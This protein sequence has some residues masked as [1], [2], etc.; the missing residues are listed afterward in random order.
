MKFLI[1]LLIIVAIIALLG[2][3]GYKT[4]GWLAERNKPRFKTARVETG[5]L[6]ISVN[7]SGEVNPVLKVKVGSFVSGPILKLHVDYNTEVKEGDP[8]ADID[9]RIYDAAVARDEA[10]LLT[11]KAD[12]LR[13]QAELQ[14]AI[15]DEKR[16]IALKSENPEFISQA[17]LDQY[18]FSR[19]ALEAQLQV[20]EAGVSQADAN[21]E[22][23]KANV[24]YTK[25]TSPVDGVVIDRKIDPG[26]TLAAQ[27]QT[28][29]LFVIAP[30]MREK[31]HIQASVDEA[32]IGLIKQAEATKQPVFFSV[33]AYPDVVFKDAII[34]QIRIAPT[35]AQNVVTYPVIVATPNPDLKLLPGMTA[36]LTFQVSELKNILKV[37]N[38]AL[39]YNPEKQHVRYI[40]HKYLELAIAQD[41]KDDE[42]KSSLEPPVDDSIAAAKAAMKRV[43]WVQ[44]TAVEAAELAKAKLEEEAKKSGK[45]APAAPAAAGPA[46]DPVTGLPA[47]SGKLKAVEIYIGDSD[48]RFTQV[49]SGNLKDGDLIVTGLKPPEAP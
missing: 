17:E 39:R 27:F 15:N 43:V 22:N 3:G 4:Q 13:V 7:A 30:Q 2:F 32:D 16:S 23:S 48:Y 26:Q 35:V 28:P 19:Q 6:R 10:A 20:A 45:P 46:T 8:L 12:V 9:P 21:L 41:P 42:A 33:D 40:D 18:R 24:A 36:N 11:R 31:M 38:E 49:T 25:I 29:E 1:R 47:L 44:E 14:R 5:D 34:E 37:P